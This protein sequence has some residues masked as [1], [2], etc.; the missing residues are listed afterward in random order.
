MISRQ[1]RFLAL[2]LCCNLVQAQTDSVDSF[3]TYDL[4]YN[5]VVTGDVNVILG[6]SSSPNVVEY[7]E[8]GASLTY[9]DGVMTITSVP[10]VSQSTV[11]IRSIDQFRSL[12]RLIVRDDSTLVAKDIR[13]TSLSVETKTSGNIKIEGIMNLNRLIMD[14]SGESEIYWVN[15]DE[16]NVDMKRGDLVLGGRVDRLTLRASDEALLDATGLISNSTWVAASGDANVQVF[17]LKTLYAYSKDSSIV[18]V[19]NKPDMYV[20]INQ[21]PSVIVLNYIDMEKRKNTVY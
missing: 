5:L 10:G 9:A 14:N 13:A 20:P 12:S 11:V 15:S 8:D 21:S 7:D 6:E 1:L 3:L 17:P 16:L 4:L 18:N 19:K 2:F